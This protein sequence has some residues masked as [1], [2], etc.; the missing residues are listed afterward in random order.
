[1]LSS[2]EIQVADK[3]SVL[4]AWQLAQLSLESATKKWIQVTL[5]G[6]KEWSPAWKMIN[7]VTWVPFVLPKNNI[8]V[9]KLPNWSPDWTDEKTLDLLAENLWSTDV[10][11]TTEWENIPAETAEYLENLWFSVYPNSQ[12]LRTIQDRFTEKEA[13]KNKWLE[14]A[15]FWVVNSQEDIESFISEH[16]WFESWYVLK[17][18]KWWYDWHGQQRIKTKDDIEEAFWKLKSAK[19][20]LI[21]EK[22]IDLSLEVSVIV[23]RDRHWNIWNLEPILNIHEWWILR[24]S[25][26]SA[27]IPKEL[28]EK[29]TESAKKLISNWWDYVWILTIEFF[30]DKDWE[31]YV[32]ELAPRTHNSWHAT[33]DNGWTSQNDLWMDAISGRTI[34]IVNWT[35]KVV[36][37]NLLTPWSLFLYRILASENSWIKFYDYLKLSENDN[38]LWT[39]IRKVW[40]ANILGDRVNDMIADFIRREKTLDDIKKI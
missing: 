31:I 37:Q 19:W 2:R 17:T 6:D 8:I 26:T 22:M 27:P 34:N 18:R 13:I 32:N 25:V 35:R 23:A 14:T 7:P 4:S 16:W 3:I 10:P 20:W 39:A 30:I 33:L 29:L 15:P 38:W 21:I 1:M 24:T 11:I 9:P 28:K 12:I 36:M 40:H 5:L